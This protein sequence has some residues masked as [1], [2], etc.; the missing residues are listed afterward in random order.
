MKKLLSGLCASAL[1]L[2][3]AAA[4]VAPVNAAPI[5]VPQTAQPSQDVQT[6]Q[7]NPSWRGD[8]WDDD[9]WWDRRDRRSMRRIQRR[10]DIAYF[11]GYRGYKYHRPGFR[12]HGDFWFPAAAFLAGALITG[13]IVNN[14]RVAS[15]SAHVDWCYDHYRSYREYDNTW[16]PRGKPR[17]ECNSPFD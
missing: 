14:N 7:F 9:D 6:V 11:N 15:G 12:R 8:R 1:A 2:S 17:R 3:F 10:G 4:T 13:A 5:F 16:K